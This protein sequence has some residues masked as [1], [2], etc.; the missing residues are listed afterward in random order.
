MEPILGVDK[1]SPDLSCG[2]LSSAKS[3]PLVWVE[4][5]PPKRFDPEVPVAAPKRL[6]DGGAAGA[7]ELDSAGLV[8]PKRALDEG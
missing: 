5:L 8:V 6:L 1:L 7:A 3:P 4:A 2:L